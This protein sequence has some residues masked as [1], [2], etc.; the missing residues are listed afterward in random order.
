MAD[1]ATSSGAPVLDGG[2]AEKKTFVK[3]ERPDEAAYKEALK[4]AEK[5]HV[6]AQDKF[7]SGTPIGS[8]DVRRM[9]DR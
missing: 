9:N 5:A 8:S 1:V 3:P 7:V 4:K 2:E 6:E